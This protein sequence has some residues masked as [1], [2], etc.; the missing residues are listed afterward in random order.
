MNAQRSSGIWVA[1]L[2]SAV[3]S[4]ATSLAQGTD[5]PRHVINPSA[6]FTDATL[7]A[8]ITNSHHRPVLDHQLDNIMPWVCSVGAAVAAADF[9]HDGWIDLY[10]TDSH[11]G[12]PNHLYLNNRDGTFIDL[13][14]QAGVAF[15]NNELEGVSMDCVVADFDNDGWPDIFLARWGHNA[16]FRNNGTNAQGLLTFADVT[17]KLFKKRDG[18]P[19]TDW[20]NAN[21]VVAW[22]YDLDGRVDFCVGNYFDEFDLWH[23][24]TTKIMH[25]DFEKARNA[26]RKF[27]YHQNPDGT[28][29]ETSAA[30]GVV[31]TGWTLALGVGDLN[32]DGWPDLYIADDF[33]QDQVF[34]NLKN[35]A[36]TNVSE[37]AIGKDTKKGM[38]AEMGDFDNDG[39]LDIYVSN[40]TTSEYLQEGNML[41]HNNGPNAE[42]LPTFTDIALEAG[43]HDGG[44]SW[45]AKFLD[46]DNDGDLDIY[47]SNGYISAGTSNYW[48]DLAS[49]TVKG[50]DVSD[51]RN[52]PAIGNRSFSGYERNRFWEN[53]GSYTFREC[54]TELGLDSNR[55]GRGLATLDYDNDGDEDIFV[56]NQAAPPH[57]FRNNLVHSNHWLTIDLVTDPSTNITRDA[58]GARITAFTASS[59]QIR[60]KNG[61]K[62]FCGGSEP[63][64]HFGLGKDDVVQLLEV[65]WPD[66]GLQ[67]YENV[68]PDRILTIRRDPNRYASQLA[69][70]LPLPKPWKRPS[71]QSQ[72]AVP[73]IDPAVLDK[74]LSELE[75]KMKKALGSYK[76]TS[77]YRKQC[78]DHEQYDRSIKFF[79]DLVAAQSDNWRARLELACSYVDKIPTCGG[80]AAIVSKG[81]LARKALDQVDIVIAKNPDAWVGYFARG[82]NHLHW[83][84]ALRHSDDAAKDLA[85]CVELQQK[86]GG[87][88]GRPYYLKVHVALGDAL[89]KGG[90]YQ[91][92][93]EAW[94]RGLQAFPLAEELRTRLATKSDKEQLKYVES[95]RS[96]ETPIDTALPFLDDEK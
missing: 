79:R 2:T 91:E 77:D 61:G 37:L 9:N 23:L 7:S 28:F 93:R 29:T 85:K 56:A 34:I 92:A 19:G 89:T 35:G 43:C 72:F 30:A 80:M 65:R 76:L 18:L 96:L 40:I 94:K 6:H 42:G 90:R 4:N 21:A 1:V 5:D 78:A 83:P 50:Q 49:W 46:Y 53:K 15:L 84:R 17:Q 14:P 60:E 13:A 3:L 55:D 75:A 25:D 8:G 87:Q 74:Q 11:F 39:W 67:Y 31:D 54:A 62:C 82:M 47:L 69:P 26:G 63:R 45:A 70:A 48:Y 22:D 10:V 41:W 64:L 81:T 33:G 16:L 51:A 59:R 57:L 58:W 38:N 52:W 32:N 36:F 88:R 66:G 12:H 71:D 95:Q 27:L 24:K 86:H 68:K 20:A 73:K 44:W